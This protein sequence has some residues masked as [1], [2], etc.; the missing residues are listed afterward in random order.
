[1]ERST[2][3]VCFFLVGDVHYHWVHPRE[4]AKF[5]G[6]TGEH[7]EC[8]HLDYRRSSSE[9]IQ[10]IVCSSIYLHIEELLRKF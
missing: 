3:E 2:L 1:M 4:G 8:E 9:L 5:I 6:S 7:T 10:C